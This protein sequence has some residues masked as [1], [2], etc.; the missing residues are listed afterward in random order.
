MIYPVYYRE[1]YG[2]QTDN[3]K[4]TDGIPVYYTLYEECDDGGEGSEIIQFGATMLD[5]IQT[6]A[7]YLNELQTIADYLNTREDE[8]E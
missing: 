1:D 2:F 8:E 3:P 6:I 7:D 4:G 5:E